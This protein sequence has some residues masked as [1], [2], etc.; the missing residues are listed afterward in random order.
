MLSI[1]A[2]ERRV[3]NI[4]QTTKGY[5]SVTSTENRR[6]L[7]Q[8]A[9]GLVAELEE[10]KE[11]AY[12]VILASCTHAAIRT[13]LDM[14]VFDAF[15]SA[16]DSTSITAGQLASIKGGSPELVS[17]IMRVLVAIG[18]CEENQPRV[19]SA[20]A[21]TKQFFAHPF[22]DLMLSQAKR[23]WKDMEQMPEYL[24]SIDY[25]DPG[26]KESDPTVFQYQNRT[27]LDYWEWLEQH[28]DQ[29][30]AF[31]ESMARTVEVERKDGN[32]GFISAFPFVNE[33]ERDHSA[34]NSIP[35]LV[36]VG[37]GRGQVLNDLRLHLP[38]LKGRLVLQDRE[39]TLKE[40]M[41]R[42]DV[43]VMPYD[44]FTRQPIIG[45]RGYLF[46]HILHD[47]PDRQACEILSNTIP[48]LV[49][50]QSRILIAEKVLP[51]VGCSQYEA[52]WDLIMM[53]V[54]GKERTESQWRSLLSSVR[55]KVV[56][57]WLA[58]GQEHVIEAIPE[59]WSQ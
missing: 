21:V 9:K 4:V 49:Q 56:K 37:G 24:A 11:S 35:V 54:S 51:S 22:S 33:L 20:N 39:E 34:G 5:V 31:N 58:S 1:A 26:E 10:P 28:P 44:F 6:K 27:N 55:L 59:H 2:V 41:C 3:E 18:A 16:Q 38:D 48:A 12:N 29:F 53:R 36:D 42:N 46:R 43:E 32:V 8:A 47:W 23:I 19:Y 50:G 40:H 45:A 13:T 15:E 30:R 25:R 57:I 17:R 14:G 52:N 7:L